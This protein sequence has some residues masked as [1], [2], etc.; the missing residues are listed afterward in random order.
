MVSCG[1]GKAAADEGGSVFDD[2]SGTTGQHSSPPPGESPARPVGS[3]DVRRGPVPT[4]TAVAAGILLLIPIAALLIV[5]IYARPT[6][7]LAGFPFFYWYQLLWVFIAS[8]FTLTAYKL[9]ARARRLP[10]G[11]R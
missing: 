9:I 7:R 11:Q 10:A 5:P 1:R 2:G 6:P 8:G 4:G 3:A